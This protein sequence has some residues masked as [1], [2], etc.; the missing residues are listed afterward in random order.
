[1]DSY[2]YATALALKPKSMM[3][4]GVPT[5]LPSDKQETFL[6]NVPGFYLFLLNVPRLLG[7]FRVCDA[8]VPSFVHPEFF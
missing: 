6:A 7:V 4:R 3:C 5:K 1:M 8:L 2:C